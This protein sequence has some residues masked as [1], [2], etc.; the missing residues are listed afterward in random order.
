MSSDDRSE[1]SIGSSLLVRVKALDPEAWRRLIR[2]Y[3]PIVYLWCVRAGVRGDDAADVGQEVFRAVADGISRFRRDRS[4]DTFVGWLRTI[5]KFKIADHKRRQIADPEAIGGTDF[6]IAVSQLAEST[7]TDSADN[8]DDG[9][10]AEHINSYVFRRALEIIQS[11]FE[12]TT[13]KAFWATAIDGRATK[14]VGADLN[15]SSMAVRKA[16]SRVLRRL[17]DEF[18]DE[19]L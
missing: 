11:E 5:T 1:A 2:I 10:T 6:Q 8:G 18:D 15:M 14:D 12:E 16:K 9:F 17:R 7:P 13:W 19:M 3:G 4:G